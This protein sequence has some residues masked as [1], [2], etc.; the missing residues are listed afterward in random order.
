MIDQTGIIF[1][2]SRSAPLCP[3]EDSD[4]LWFQLSA[5]RA[6]RRWSCGAERRNKTAP[7]SAEGDRHKPQQHHHKMVGGVRG[8]QRSNVCL[9]RLRGLVLIQPAPYRQADQNQ[10][11]RANGST[12]P[13]GCAHGCAAPASPWPARAPRG[14]CGSP[15]TRAPP[16]RRR[17]AHCTQGPPNR[18]AEN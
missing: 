13:S 15:H 18:P 6:P 1:R 14:A 8:C 7:S 16:D 5:I 3:S 9:G 4:V 17:P 2:P 10:Q 11:S 12:G